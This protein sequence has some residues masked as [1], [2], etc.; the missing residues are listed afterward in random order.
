MQKSEGGR[1]ID[2][3]DLVYLFALF[4]YFIILDYLCIY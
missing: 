1:N 4:H 3:K 2:V